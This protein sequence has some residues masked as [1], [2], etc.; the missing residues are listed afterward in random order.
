MKTRI[1]LTEESDH[2]NPKSRVYRAVLSAF[3]YGATS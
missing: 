3:F 2:G 1:E